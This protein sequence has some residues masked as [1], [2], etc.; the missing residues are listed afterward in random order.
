MFSEVNNDHVLA[1]IT[2]KAS[3]EL[4]QEKKDKEKHA[5]VITENP[6]VPNITRAKA[7]ELNKAQ[8]IAFPTLGEQQSEITSLIKDDLHSDEDDEEYMF[9]EEDFHVTTLNKSIFE[10]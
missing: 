9:Q 7:R 6:S 1:F 4:T 2:L 3:T 5:F 8:I 10:F